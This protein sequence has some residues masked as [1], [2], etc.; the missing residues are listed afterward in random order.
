MAFDS[1]IRLRQ[2]NQPELS[3]YISSVVM[4][5]IKA[6]GIIVNSGIFPT[7]SGT[8][9]IGSSSF[10]FDQIY[11]KQIILPSGSGINFGA[12]FFTAYTS[13]ADAVI[14]VGSY[15]I[16][17]SPI[18]LSIIGASGA[19]GFVGASGAT[20]AT[21]I[22]VTGAVSVNVTG[23][24]LL[25]SDGTS[26]NSISLPSGATGASGASVTGFTQSGNYAFAL[27]SNG[28]TGTSI[29][30]PSG[31]TGRQGK[32]GGII[33]NI[34]DFTGWTGSETPKAYIYDID[35][36]GNTYNPTINLVRGMSYD[37]GYSGLNLNTVNILGTDYNTN[38]FIESGITGYLKLVFFESTILS[39]N[40]KTGRFIS[41]ELDSTYFTT[42]NSALNIDT[43]SYNVEEQGSRAEQTF[44]VRLSSDNS[45][46]WGFQKY[47]F[48]NQEPIDE[49]GAWGFYVLGDTNVSH[50]GPSGLTG[51]QGASG[52]PGTRGNPGLRGLA[53]TPGNS[54]TGTERQGNDIRLALSDGTFTEWTTLPAGGLQGPIGP[55][56]TGASG[57]Q[58]PI[59]PMGIADRYAGNFTINDEDD[60]N[61]SGSGSAMDIKISPA[62]T[63]TFT[64]GNNRKFVPG[65]EIRFRADGLINKAYSPWQ[66]MIFADSPASRSQYFYAYV[67]EFTPSI[68]QMSCVVLSD[69]PPLG[70]DGGYIKL[71]QY[72]T[73]EF[74]L[75]GLGSSGAIGLTGPSGLRGNT[76]NALFV[77]NQPVIGLVEGVNTLN[78]NVNDFKFTELTSN[79][80]DSI[81][82]NSGLIS[83]VNLLNISSHSG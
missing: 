17:S 10:P 51:R 26:G 59:G 62:S 71:F 5:A 82:P 7:A 72:A 48:F 9:D 57:V 43:L 61:I 29:S 50:F 18:G 68:G 6:S 56:G 83:V 32:V 47:N 20:G 75:G 25:F 37:F 2:L 21:G 55:P 3:G 28:T 23:F 39:D 76:G 4:P 64:T 46:K 60:I 15:T 69:P 77:I 22:S 78:F 70:L 54:I 30:L 80:Q 49:L 74:N 13:G 16:T 45:Y 42:L 73:V 63:F 1:L 52:A 58:G 41:Q 27:F 34:N 67:T 65:D 79:S 8:E 33:L 38:Y 24:R 40:P 11:A 53:G 31:A 36:L 81:S 14:K 12:D 35:P 19:T 44:A 66:K